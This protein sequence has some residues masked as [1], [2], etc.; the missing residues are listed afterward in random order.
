MSDNIL[1]N[2]NEVSKGEIEEQ[3]RCS[4]SK[5]NNKMADI[6]LTI[7]IMTLNKNQ[8]NIPFRDCQMDFKKFNYMLHIRDTL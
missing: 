6:N 2:M 3:K 8:L 1:F 4:I 5:I 7:A